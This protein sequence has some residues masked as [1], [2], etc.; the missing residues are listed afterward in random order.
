MAATAGERIPE[1]PERSGQVNQKTVRRRLLGVDA[2]R[3]IALLGM[4]AAHI[5]PLYDPQTGD[6]TWVGLA[7]SGRSAALF[8]VLAGVGLALLTG[9]GNPH[10]RYR[11]SAGGP[12][13]IGRDRRGIAARAGVIAFIGLTL[14]TLD[15]N[16]A[17]ILVHYA[18]LFLLALPF[19]ALRLRWLAV[20]A[21]GWILVAPLLAYLVRPW[22]VDT[23][24]PSP[25]LR[26]NPVLED[27]F[28]PGVLL[29]DLTV[30]GIYPVLLWLGYLLVGLVI[31]RLAL[32]KLHVQ[33]MLLAAGAAVAA[34]SKLLG[35]F[36]MGPLGGEAALLQTEEGSRW[37]LHDMLQV[38]LTGVEQ[39]GSFWWLL[40]AAPH[41]GTTLDLLHTSG[42][43]AAVIGLC[44]LAARRL[45]AFLL[46]L[47]GAGAMT[48]TLY[49]THVWVMSIV[50]AQPEPL[51]PNA[52]YIIQA[53]AVLAI[54]FLFAALRWRGPLE[55]VASNVAQLA[56]GEE[57]A[58]QRPPGR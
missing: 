30:T 14:G 23:L 49:S 2:A 53:I 46:P 32:Q 16:I 7:V 13:L 22:L 33:L 24:R 35:A 48:L 26:H 19:V 34:I 12:S 56:R 25:S 31:G 52:V 27:L 37:P 55:W 18:L 8:A 57:P 10:E 9:G 45:G 42:S 20:W 11:A 6:P 38:N 44:L 5:L 15:T 17:I 36:F 39:T 21:A 43:A 1:Q 29:A 51:D 4:M 3:G 50:D 41:S 47:C 28:T 40:T 54:G 58:G